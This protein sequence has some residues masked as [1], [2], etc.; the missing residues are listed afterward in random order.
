M[1]HFTTIETQIRDVEAL[2]AACSEMGLRVI[3][4]TEARGFGANRRHGEL[5]VDY[6]RTARLLNEALRTAAGDR[7][8]VNMIKPVMNA[9][10]YKAY[11]QRRRKR[12][13]K[14]IDVAAPE[15]GEAVANEKEAA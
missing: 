9:A 8:L 15:K 3:R 1:S 5:K 11:H 7:E 2:C 6:P 12:D 10:E 4:N 14:P 13:G